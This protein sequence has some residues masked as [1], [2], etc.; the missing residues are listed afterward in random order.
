MSK[1]LTILCLSSVLGVCCGGDFF[2]IQ[3]LYEPPVSK[4]Q[5]QDDDAF[6]CNPLDLESLTPGPLFG[7]CGWF[8]V[9]PDTGVVV[10]ADHAE[11]R[12]QTIVMTGDQRRVDY[13]GWVAIPPQRGVF[14]VTVTVHVDTLNAQSPPNFALNLNDSANYL[15]DGAP[16]PIFHELGAMMYLRGSVGLVMGR[17]GNGSGGGTLATPPTRWKRSSI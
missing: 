1:K 11:V 16:W 14:S 13:W 12:N 17:D 15:R 5:L 2:S 7:N 9:Q 4:A 8:T 3:G 10:G 6:L